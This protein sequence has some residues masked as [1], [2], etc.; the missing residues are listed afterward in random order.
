MHFKGPE[1][2]IWKE[3][4][5]S[6]FAPPF[7]KQCRLFSAKPWR[8]SSM[9]HNNNKY[10]LKIRHFLSCFVFVNH[11]Y[12]RNLKNLC[13]T[14]MGEKM[15]CRGVPLRKHDLAHTFLSKGVTQGKGELG[16]TELGAYTV[17]KQTSETCF[18]R[19][20]CPLLLLLVNKNG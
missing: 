13:D 10:Y 2:Y 16:T 12:F 4:E 7:I 17:F 9:D 8:H 14:F 18:K 11:T 15:L 3:I 6:Y 20:S 1:I 19:Q 5:P